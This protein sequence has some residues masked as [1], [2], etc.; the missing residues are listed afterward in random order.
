[1][2]R[3]KEAIS[4]LERAVDLTKGDAEI[5]EHL[6]DVYLKVGRSKEA[7]QVYKDAR[8][9]LVDSKESEDKISAERI[10]NKIEEISKTKIQKNN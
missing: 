3:I 1:M 6:A 7:L 2:G 8:D 9:N 10:R 5:S 4:D